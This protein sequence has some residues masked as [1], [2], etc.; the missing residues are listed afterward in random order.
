MAEMEYATSGFNLYPAD[1]TIGTTVTS[2]STANTYGS[3][4]EIVASTGADV[5]I[6]CVLARV[7][8]GY[9]VGNYIQISIGTG[10]SGS[11]V[12]RCVVKIIPF[13]GDGG[14]GFFAI[15][16]KLRVASGTRIAC[17]VAMSLNQQCQC[18]ITL[19]YIP[20]SNIVNPVLQEVS[21]PTGAVV[22]D[23]G[24][25]ASSFKTN[26][27]ETTNDYWKDC[28]L[29]FTSGSL[30][31]QVKKITGYN[32][33]TKFVTCDAFTGTPSAGATFEIINQ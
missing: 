17:R 18:L 12:E 8:P 22:S 29:K 28:Y 14:S 3:W 32:G 24:N 10:G 30:I 9:P 11:E 21:N 27:T 2:G 31:N 20:V 23:S 5:Y 15:M 13:L 7:L 4:T 25:S 26:L 19:A 16:P 6:Y 1:P 33:T